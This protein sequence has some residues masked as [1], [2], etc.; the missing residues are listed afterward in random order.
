M[1][2]EGNGRAAAAANHESINSKTY[3]KE[4]KFKKPMMTYEK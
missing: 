3:S 4:K 2:D 1:E